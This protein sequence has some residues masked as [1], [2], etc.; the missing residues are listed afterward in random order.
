MHIKIF[1]LS[2]FFSIPF[3]LS[4][5]EIVFE[6]EMKIKTNTESLFVSYPIVDEISNEIALFIMTRKEVKAML[7]TDEF[8]L[9][10]NYS[11]S[12]DPL[13]YKSI[14]GHNVDSKGYNFFFTDLN[15]K[16]IYV[17]SVDI[18]GKSDY[19]KDQ[20]LKLKKEKYL[21]SFIYKN[22]FH[23]MTIKKYSSVLFL[24]VFDGSELV[25]KQ[26][27]DFSK[28]NFSENKHDNLFDVLRKHSVSR[29]NKFG[30]IKMDNE[31]FN[32]L[33]I[34]SNTN[35]LYCFNDQLHLTFDNNTSGTKMISIDLDDYDSE[36]KFI[37]QNELICENSIKTKS[38][39]FLYKNSLF[40]I[41][42]CNEEFKFSVFDLNTDSVVIS[43]G[44]AIE[45]E[46]KFKNTNL[47][48]DGG[49]N[50]ITHGLEKDLTKTK[51]FLRKITMS[52][53]GVAV[54]DLNENLE[55]TIGGFKEVKQTGILLGSYYG[56][57]NKSSLKV[58][59]S[60]DTNPTNYAYSSKL[61]A[62]TRSVYFKTLLDKSDFSH[63]KGEVLPKIYDDIN[64]FEKTL[65]EDLY[66][67]T[68]FKFDNNY[69]LGNYNKNEKKYTLWK[70]KDINVNFL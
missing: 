28:Y 4:S 48:Q 56:N 26:E 47:I 57:L 62:N 52:K 40:Q 69:I 27:F 3:S 55:V 24:Y 22:K 16:K 44:A 31:N 53:V 61:L 20:F 49:T 9:M 32:S 41:V 14:L 66:I 33:E 12:V 7:F 63:Q 43:Y 1:V 38:N 36:A 21:E 30:F 70:S 65:G 25:K 34:S 59:P 19:I 45:Q 68:I 50:I 15:K 60:Y 29:K 11:F 10:A 51:Q 42:A 58:I 54:Y 5:Q 39:S 13:L 2:L 67:K 18:E 6:K 35:K 23:I 17:H 8:Y 46:I 37:P 64:N